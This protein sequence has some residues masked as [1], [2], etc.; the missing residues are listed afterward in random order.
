MIV[1]LSLGLFSFSQ[2]ICDNGVDD[3]N[4]GLI[5]LNDTADCN[6]GDLKVNPISLVPN[7]SF[8]E[9]IC[10]P[11]S[12]SQ[13]N[14]AKNWVQASTAT[15][16]Y[17]NTCGYIGK[18]LF[19]GQLAP[20]PKFNGEGYVGYYDTYFG[21]NHY[22]EYIGTCLNKNMVTG[23]EYQLEFY[24]AYGQGPKDIS[25]SLFA[26]EDCSNLPFGGLDNY[27]GCPT[28][29][30]GWD[31]LTSDTLVL[32]E[33]EWNLVRMRFTPT[34]DY[35]AIVLGPSCQLINKVDNELPYYYL[36]H[37]IVNKSELFGG[38]SLTESVEL[39]LKETTLGIPIEMNPN[40][41]QWY[42]DGVA[43]QGEINS[44]LKVDNSQK[45]VYQAR[46]EFDDSCM[47]SKAHK[48]DSAKWGIPVVSLRDSMV[49]CSGVRYLIADYTLEP[50]SIYWFKDGKKLVVG[51]T[52]ILS[53]TGENGTY[54]VKL[55]Y[56]DS[57]TY[58]DT[59][60]IEPFE[61]DSLNIWL[62]DTLIGCQ[63][64]YYL[65]GS[66]GNKNSVFR[67]FK[68]EFILENET[69][70]ILRLTSSS[71]GQFSARVY[72]Q[73]SCLLTDEIDVFSPKNDDPC[74][75]NFQVYNVFTPGLDEFNAVWL[76]DYIGYSSIQ[77]DIF[78]RWGELIY[79]Y[80]LPKDEGWNG[81]VN[82]IGNLCPDGT[83]FYILKLKNQYTDK[84][85]RVNGL[86]K[87]IS[88]Q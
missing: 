7:S 22:K 14:C 33:K 4:D 35:S 2:E 36:D 68:D 21:S 74:P 60:S 73:D 10:C 9:K 52:N 62:V 44:T 32:V 64:E 3:D 28:N 88:E 58:S 71:R 45:G 80:S 40:S 26:T 8:E 49:Q 18:Q 41:I 42:L 57:C 56:G 13:L 82:N 63:H 54:I 87:L 17:F 12:H 48:G 50:K 61:T 23:E 25:V 20:T 16:D 1:F 43:I 84:V 38:F 19:F 66:T 31:E 83:Y 6:C 29:D 67:W 59:I 77:V 46:L 76:I 39:C 30:V 65:E 75:T 15:S 79:G 69:N 47:V 24:L 27:I 86:I 78:N 81:R 34:K 11:T 85:S 5:D 70:P 53:C 72:S 55:E 51:D 37:I